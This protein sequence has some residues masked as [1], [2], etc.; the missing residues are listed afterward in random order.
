MFVF[1]RI[2]TSVRLRSGNN[3]THVNTL[4]FSMPNDIYSVCD[5]RN[6]GITSGYI[7]A[8]KGDKKVRKIKALPNTN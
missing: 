2:G 5:N 7:C 1:I 3:V 8:Y 6:T 4:H